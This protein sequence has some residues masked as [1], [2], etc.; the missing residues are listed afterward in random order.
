[1]KIHLLFQKQRTNGQTFFFFFF[2]LSFL[3]SSFFSG[4][5]IA[6]TSRL[7]STF[8]RN[9]PAPIPEPSWPIRI[10]QTRPTSKASILNQPIREHLFGHKQLDSR[11]VTQL[12]KQKKIDF[13]VQ[14]TLKI[15]VVPL[16]KLL[17]RLLSCINSV[18]PSSP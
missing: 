16:S 17:D 1:M 7:T 6:M 11:N 18:F 5:T 13:H 8:S 4:F 3:S 2:F 14:L 15:S 10:L 12:L 9:H